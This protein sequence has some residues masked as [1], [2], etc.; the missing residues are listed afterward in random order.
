MAAPGQKTSKTARN[1]AKLQ[2]IPKNGRIEKRPLLHPAVNSPYA[3]SSHQKVIYVSASTPFIAAVK[4]VRKFLD[5]IEKRSRQSEQHSIDKSATTATAHEGVVLKATGKATFRALELALYF[6]G[7]P[8]CQI[9][10]RT[11]SVGTVD[12]IVYAENEPDKV[13]EEDA[14]AIDTGATAEATGSTTEDLPDTQIR[15]A[16][17]LEITISLR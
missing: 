17:T 6:Q 15:R 9:V 16:S 3:G 12:D 2:R 11:S 13:G 1:P 7:Q 10:I 8:D 14:A 4:R 5:A